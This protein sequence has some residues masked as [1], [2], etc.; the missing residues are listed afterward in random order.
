MRAQDMYPKN[1]SLPCL[2]MGV[3]ISFD[4]SDSAALTHMLTWFRDYFGWES[5]DLRA[6]KNVR[7]D[8]LP[9]A[10]NGRR[11]SYLRE[12][13][14]QFSNFNPETDKLDHDIHI[15]FLDAHRILMIEYFAEVVHFRAAMIA[16][17]DTASIEFADE[18]HKFY[19]GVTRRH[20]PK[21]LN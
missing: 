21:L 5:D 2:P 4:T 11:N 14:T 6:R 20:F 17:R 8:L 16:T 10:Q 13:I 19:D 1:A 3:W 9:L 7:D 15:G 18:L 12:L